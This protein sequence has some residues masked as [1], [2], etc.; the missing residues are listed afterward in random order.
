LAKKAAKWRALNAWRPATG[1]SLHAANLVMRMLFGVCALT[2][3]L[4]QCTEKDKKEPQMKTYRNRILA[5]AAMGL[6]AIG[7][8]VSPAAAQFLSMSIDTGTF[9]LPY[10][11]RWQSVTLPAGDYKF[12]LNSASLP[13]AITLRGPK[14]A[15][16]IFATSVD[17]K[18]N[19][20][21]SQLTIQHKLGNDY[22]QELYLANL[23]L[24][25]NYSTPKM[26]KGG[27]QL[28]E[29]P[30]LDHIAVASGK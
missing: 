6:V 25:V 3:K 21:K 22:V 16:T 7:I 5:V 26:P 28:A 30:S 2:D 9:T 8:S 1:L 17:P 27:Q 10:E 13:A 24:H 15:A 20:E 23:G 14:G 12:S 11:V 4:R 29:T 18:K 19:G